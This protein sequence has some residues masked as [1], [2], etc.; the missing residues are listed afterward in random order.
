MEE[1]L[2][3]I[4]DLLKREGKVKVKDLSERFNVSEGMIRKDLS[5]LEKYTNIK[6]T[7]G[8][9]I[10]ERK[11][12]HDEGTSSRVIQNLDEKQIIAEIVLNEIEEN[13]VVFLDIS[14]TNY[15]VSNMMRNFN[16]KMTLITNMNRIAMDFDHND[17]VNVIQIGG[18]YNKKLGGTVGAFSIEEISKF[19]ID[20]AFIGA[21]GINI[22][23]NFISN[24]DLEEAET[25][26]AIIKSSKFTY[27]VGDNEKFYKD[28]SYKFCD[29]KDIEYII[30]DIKPN[31]EI[32]KKLSESNVKVLY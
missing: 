22:E 7:Y 18:T 2:E 11:I 26:K 1:R 30:T 14:S 31:E 17:N 24:F 20:K 25:K 15:M 8:G 23:D 27:L 21:G 13:D 28:G 12:V 10:L 4:L 9:A 6:R 5:K 29:I 19:K 32:L 16:K 3:D